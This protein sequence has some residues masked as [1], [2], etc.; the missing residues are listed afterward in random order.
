MM[1]KT[2]QIRIDEGMKA[3][4]EE[5]FSSLGL[6]ISTAVRMFFASSIQNQGLPFEVR[7]FNN[8]T[9]QAMEDA[10]LRRNLYGP[11]DTVEE[12]MANLD[13]DDDEIRKANKA[14]EKS[15][16]DYHA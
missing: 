14:A 6:D 11:F 9:I 4:V 16:Y 15:D 10:R 7:R 1:A 2:I 12:M 13:S 8:E 5:L 3:N